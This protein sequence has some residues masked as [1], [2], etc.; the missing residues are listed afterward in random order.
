MMVGQCYPLISIMYSIPL[1]A[2]VHDELND[3]CSSLQRFQRDTIY[4]YITPYS[5]PIS[6]K[7]SFSCNVILIKCLPFNH[8]L[9][10]HFTYEDSIILC[11]GRGMKALPECHIS[12]TSCTK[13]RIKFSC[14]HFRNIILQENTVVA[15]LLW[16]PLTNIQVQQ[17]M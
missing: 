11:Q 5:L 10:S 15:S 3:G 16:A 17:Q 14:K 8:S 9:F 12:L 2:N 1:Y 6:K 4:M 7:G 13:D